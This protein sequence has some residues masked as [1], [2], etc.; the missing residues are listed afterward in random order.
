MFYSGTWRLLCACS[1]AQA[2]AA[3]AAT[4]QHVRGIGAPL[5]GVLR[6]EVSVQPELVR[7][8]RHAVPDDSVRLSSL[9][10]DRDAA[11]RVR[12]ERHERL[13]GR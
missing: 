4:G 8:V 11:S 2:A 10:R 7:V 13:T 9:V 3:A 6:A 5:V 12:G 1:R